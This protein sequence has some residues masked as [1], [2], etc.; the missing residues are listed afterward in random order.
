MSE[1]DP[2]RKRDAKELEASSASVSLLKKKKKLD[3]DSSTDYSHGV[4]L[5]IP[6]VASSDDSSRGGCSVN[7]AGEDDDKSSIICLSTESKS[8]SPTVAADLQAHQISETETSTSITSSSIRKAVNPVSEEALGETT[9]MESSSSSA[10]KVSESP[11]PGEIEEFLSE[12]E[13]KDQKRFIEK[14]NFDIVNDKPLQGR[15][16]WGSI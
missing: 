9:E 16:K 3:D 13:N 1:R 14:Y 7:S 6:S 11:T 15:Y 10:Q 5:A 4:V 8:S 2:N 12:L